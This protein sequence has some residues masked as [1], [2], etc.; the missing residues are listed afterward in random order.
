MFYNTIGEAYIPIA[1]A[2]AAKVD[3]NAELFYND[4]NLELNGDKAAGARRIVQLVQSYGVKIQGV[5]L[6]SH[7]AI[8]ETPTAGPA[9]DLATLTAALKGFTKLGVDVAYT[10]IDAR[11]NTPPTPAK[12]QLQ[13]DV[14]ERIATSCLNVKRC[15]GMTVW[16]RNALI[17]CLD[18]MC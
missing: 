15:I 12:L 7:V 13:A 18:R 9:P 16:V 17:T 2:H 1:F 6:Q 8:E 5:G 10:E 4:Y 3:P 14:Y 11:M